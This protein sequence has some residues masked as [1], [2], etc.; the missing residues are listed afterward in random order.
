MP[1]SGGAFSASECSQEHPPPPNP[2][3][4]TGPSGLFIAT[5]CFCVRN[6]QGGGKR[7]QLCDDYHRTPY[8]L[9]AYFVLGRFFIIGANVVVSITTIILIMLAVALVVAGIVYSEWAHRH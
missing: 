6:D 8:Q 1:H 4:N 7:R 5:K 2:S 9:G 3:D